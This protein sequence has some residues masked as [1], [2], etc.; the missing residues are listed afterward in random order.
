MRQLPFARIKAVSPLTNLIVS[1]LPLSGVFEIRPGLYSYVSKCIA[2][3]A[4]LGGVQQGPSPEVAKE[5]GIDQFLFTVFSRIYQFVFVLH[6]Y[7][8]IRRFL[9]KSCLFKK[10]ISE[11]WGSDKA[12]GP[13][14]D[15]TMSR[16][17]KNWR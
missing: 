14:S 9:L 12:I 8:S 15:F 6:I 17:C 4:P 11:I 1:A 10:K 5:P 13:R 7:N 2:T 16:P 3:M